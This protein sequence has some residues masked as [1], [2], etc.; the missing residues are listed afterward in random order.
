MSS[1]PSNAA[2][3]A[4]KRWSTRSQ[5]TAVALTVLLSIGLIVLFGREPPPEQIIISGPVTFSSIFLPPGVEIELSREAS[6]GFARL[7]GSGSDRIEGKLLEKAMPYGTFTVQGR[8]FDWHHTSFIADTRN[9]TRPRVWHSQVLANMLRSLLSHK[10]VE[11]DDELEPDLSGFVIAPPA[12]DYER[13][14]SDL[15]A[16]LSGFEEQP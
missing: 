1:E 13:V 3:P 12:N 15:E 6:A 11:I 14:R 8:S 9:Q 2:L 10:K 7:I 4:S 5:F 16:D